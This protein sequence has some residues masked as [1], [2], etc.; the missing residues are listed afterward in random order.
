MSLG[1]LR[2]VVEEAKYIMQSSSAY[3]R[4]R[5][6]ERISKSSEITLL[7][8]GVVVPQLNNGVVGIGVDGWLMLMQSTVGLGDEAMLETILKWPMAVEPDMLGRSTVDD[9]LRLSVV[10]I[11]V[12]KV[13]SIVSIVYFFVLRMCGELL[14]MMIDYVLSR[15]S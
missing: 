7:L 14:L 2:D 9:D 4:L 6:R 11:L 5:F 3:P 1:R 8:G 15:W 10:T 13:C 12:N